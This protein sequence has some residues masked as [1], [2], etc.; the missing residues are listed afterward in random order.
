MNSDVFE[1][2]FEEKLLPNLPEKCIIVLDNPSYH[3]RQVEKIPTMNTLKADMINFIK[4]HGI[5][6]S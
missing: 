1:H 5:K 4:D 3:S 6:S 2:W